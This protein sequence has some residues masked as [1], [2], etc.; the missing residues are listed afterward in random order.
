MKKSTLSKGCTWLASRTECPARSDP[1]ANQAGAERAEGNLVARIALRHSSAQ[2]GNLNIHKTKNR[3]KH[4]YTYKHKLSSL[5]NLATKLLIIIAS[6]Y[7]LPERVW[8]LPG[9]GVPARQPAPNSLL[10]RSFFP[11]CYFALYDK[12]RGFQRTRP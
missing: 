9:A 7:L 2:P 6:L 8:A 1:P 5:S 4:N 12:N 10:S 11:K 3:Q